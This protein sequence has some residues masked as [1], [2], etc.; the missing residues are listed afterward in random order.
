MTGMTAL[1]LMIGGL[2]GGRGGMMI[3]LMFAGLMNFAAYWFSDQLVLKLY[4]AQP[5]SQDHLVSRMVAKLAQR[6]GI[7]TP[8]IS[9]QFRL[10]GF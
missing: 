7:P 8:F 2:L 5:L 10:N 9:H 6:A 3:A 4:K 1:L